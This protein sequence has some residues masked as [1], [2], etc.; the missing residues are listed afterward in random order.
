MHASQDAD[1][2]AAV[3]IPLIER[4]HSYDVVFEVRAQHLKRQP[5]E[6]CLP[7]GH[8]EPGE[9]A[10]EAAVRETC[11]EL[12][13]DVSQLREI[14][15]LGRINGPGGLPLRL[16]AGTLSGYDGSFDA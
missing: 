9:S 7:G 10:R 6:V 15:D 5:G 3:F 16:F 14:V 11:E 1:C 4:E 8:I 12:L 2:R 13:V